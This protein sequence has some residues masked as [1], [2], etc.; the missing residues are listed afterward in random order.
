VSDPYRYEAA[1][2]KARGHVETLKEI[3][4]SC[5]DYKQ[6]FAELE[7]SKTPRIIYCDPPYQ[8][9]NY[10]PKVWKEFSHE[11]FWGIVRD[12]QVAHPES[13]VFVSERVAPSDFVC[14]WEKTSKITVGTANPS[15]TER[16]FIH[17]SVVL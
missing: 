14:I 13:I 4:L 9:P 12:Y 10:T 8:I 2:R 17:A 16:I 1:L 5:Q 7:D 3:K 11:E 6:V 15:Q